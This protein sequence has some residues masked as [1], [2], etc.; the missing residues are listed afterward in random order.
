MLTEMR[1]LLNEVAMLAPENV[2]SMARELFFELGARAEASL[3]GVEDDRWDDALDA[4]G[5]EEKGS[6]VRIAELEK[7]LTRR[8]RR[9]ISKAK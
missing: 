5:D 7:E 1:G 2:Y 6:L 3:D 4:I 8:M 9:D